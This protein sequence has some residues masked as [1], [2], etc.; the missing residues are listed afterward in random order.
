M[1]HGQQPMKMHTEVTL[2]Y[3]HRY[4]KNNFAWSP[5]FNYLRPLLDWCR[6]TVIA[7]PIVINISCVCNFQRMRMFLRFHRFC[8]FRTKIKVAL[9]A[10]VR[11]TCLQF[12]GRSPACIAMPPCY[13]F[14]RKILRGVDIAQFVLM[15]RCLDWIPSRHLL[16]S[17]WKDQKNVNKSKYK[18]LLFCQNLEHVYT[19]N[20][21]SKGY[22]RVL[23][24][25]NG[26]WIL[27]VFSRAIT[28]SNTFFFIFMIDSSA[29]TIV[30]LG[31][32]QAITMNLHQYRT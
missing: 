32:N 17:I 9:G 12:L 21:S 29:S 31:E 2:L 19:Y 5:W 25:W 8:T 24:G 20:V 3:N 4:N 23:K 13:A 26:I 15:S 28:D 14:R 30:Y 11:V 22:M 10:S 1:D 6:S 7:N 27:P 16:P 18:M